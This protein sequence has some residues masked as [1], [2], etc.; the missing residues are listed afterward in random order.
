MQVAIS[1]IH[2]PE[3]YWFL[4]RKCRPADLREIILGRGNSAEHG[5]CEERKYDSQQ[6]VPLLVSDWP[7]IGREESPTATTILS[8]IHGSSLESA[9]HYAHPSKLKICV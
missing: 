5:D 7:N 6:T 4:A 8:A 2:E 1:G 9:G 3:F